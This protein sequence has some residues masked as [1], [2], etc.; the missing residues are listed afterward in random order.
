MIKAVIFDL[1]MC[2]LDTHTLTGLFFQPV[3][4]VLYNSNLPPE[5]KEKINYQLWTTSLDDAIEMFSVP[6]DIAERMKEA[7]RRIEVPDGIKTFGD[8]EYIRDL[9]VKK[10]LVTTGYRKFQETKIEK[11]DIADLFDEII[12]DELDYTKK[13]KGKKKIFGELLKKNE[14]KEDEVLVVGDNPI[15]ELGAAKSLG[16]STVQTLRPTIVKWDEADYHICSFSELID[17]VHL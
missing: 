14:W 17:L 6:G 11:L 4:D 16:I 10:I 2:I 12:I 9:S 8:E 7:Y 13:R 1:D 5:L 15:S 3:L